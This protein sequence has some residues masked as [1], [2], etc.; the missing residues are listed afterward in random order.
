MNNGSF[1][2]F[3]DNQRIIRTVST[4]TRTLSRP[5]RYAVPHDWS[6]CPPELG[7]QEVVPGSAE[8]VALYEARVA[9]HMPPQ[10]PGDTFADWSR[11]A[12]VAEADE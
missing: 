1:E 2:G 8:T 10:H 9:A 12:E 5:R 7:P 6:T 11:V 4:G 3:S